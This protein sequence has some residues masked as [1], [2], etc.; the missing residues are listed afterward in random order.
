MKIRPV[1]PRLL[2]AEGRTDRETNMT[3]LVV[4]LLV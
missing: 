4:F 2:H 3:T 1:R